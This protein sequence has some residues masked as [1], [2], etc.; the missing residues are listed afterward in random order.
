MITPWPERPDG[1]AWRRVVRISAAAY[2]D[3]AQYRRLAAA[4]PA[5]ISAAA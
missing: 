1:G 2:N 3:S 4:L 5:A